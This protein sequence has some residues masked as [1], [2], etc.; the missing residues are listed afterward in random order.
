MS[1]DLTLKKMQ[2]LSPVQNAEDCNN[3]NMHNCSKNAKLSLLQIKDNPRQF[4]VK[5]L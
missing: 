4:Q 2:T 3:I 5:Y 1:V